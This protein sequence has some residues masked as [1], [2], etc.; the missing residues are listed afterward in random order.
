MSENTGLWIVQLVKTTTVE[1]LDGFV[2]VV[3]D[4]NHPLFK[5]KNGELWKSACSIKV[6]DD[7]R[8]HVRAEK[9]LTARQRT[10]VAGLA[11][12]YWRGG[13]ER[14]RRE[15]WRRI[16]QTKA[17]P[18]AS[19]ATCFWVRADQGEPGYEAAHADYRATV[20]QSHPYAHDSSS[21]RWFIDGAKEDAP[22]D[23]SGAS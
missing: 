16:R 20:V 5:F 23:V 13:P 8:L 17:R 6:W 15:K 11:E 1:S 10:I 9:H 4:G 22:L 3:F 21:E 19:R 12:E 18:M 14:C 2:T 7:G